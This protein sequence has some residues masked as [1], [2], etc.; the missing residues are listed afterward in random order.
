MGLC[1]GRI[2]IVENAYEVP[3]HGCCSAGAPNLRIARNMI[4]FFARRGERWYYVKIGAF[5]QGR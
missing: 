4:A 1:D 5:E 2:G 3:H